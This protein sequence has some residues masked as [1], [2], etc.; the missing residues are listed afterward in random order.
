[1]GAGGDQRVD[2]GL[3]PG[4][5]FVVEVG[6]AVHQLAARHGHVEQVPRADHDQ[7]DLGPVGPGGVGPLHLPALALGQVLGEA[8]E[9]AHDAPGVHEAAPLDRAVADGERPLDARRQVHGQRV[10]LRVAHQHD[11]PRRG[12]GGGG[13]R[14]GLGGRRGRGVVRVAVSAPFAVPTVGSKA[15]SAERST[16]RFTSSAVATPG[17]ERGQHEHGHRGVQAGPQLPAPA[18]AQPGPPAT[19]HAVAHGLLDVAV[20]ELRRRHRGR[21][22][23]RQ[24]PDALID[25]GQHEAGQC[26]R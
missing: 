17:Q 23:Q 20:A 3:Q 7:G 5:Q 19:E 8:G 18:G 9:H 15:T 24:P 14:R 4:L 11:A 12:D 25:P 22:G 2:A 1:M 6:R 21:Q 10:G 16:A 26:H 13:R